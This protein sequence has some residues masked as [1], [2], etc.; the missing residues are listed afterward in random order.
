MKLANPKIKSQNLD[1]VGLQEI[2][3]ADAKQR[4]TLLF[5]PMAE[6]SA[7]GVWWIRANQGHSITVSYL[8]LHLSST[9]VEQLWTDSGC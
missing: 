5:E 2:V 7:Q 9:R 4:Y 8:N 1:L 6:E 3:K